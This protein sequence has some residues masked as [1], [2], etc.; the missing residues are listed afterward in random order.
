MIITT[1]ALLGERWEDMRK[2]ENNVKMD[3]KGI[4]RGCGL[5]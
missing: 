2:T 3:M 4:D 1:C 5:A